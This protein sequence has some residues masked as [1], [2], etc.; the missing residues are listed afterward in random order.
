MA[1]DTTS[2]NADSRRKRSNDLTGW[3]L[4]TDRG[5]DVDLRVE[6]CVNHRL[7]RFAR[8]L[9]SRAPGP[10]RWGAHTYSSGLSKSRPAGNKQLD[11]LR[12]RA[13]EPAFE[14]D[15]QR[16]EAARFTDGTVDDDFIASSR[17][18]Q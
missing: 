8:A 14:E 15:H 11:V 2:S 12:P 9:T 17:P 1:G 3:P 6:N 10:G 5:A 18:I 16:D 13:L 4:G 7:L